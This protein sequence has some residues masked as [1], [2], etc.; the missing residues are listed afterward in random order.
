MERIIKFRAWDGTRLLYKDLFDDNWY[1]SSDWNNSKLVRP[2]N[3]SDIN[4]MQIMQYT[5][6][7]D[8]NGVEIYDGDIVKQYSGRQWESIYTVVWYQG[9]EFHCGWYLDKS[10]L[11]MGIDRAKSLEVIGNKYENPE[12]LSK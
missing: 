5:G 9:D 6:L 10:Q 7:K 3:Q 4:T 2:V 8:K 1:T 11:E 12:L